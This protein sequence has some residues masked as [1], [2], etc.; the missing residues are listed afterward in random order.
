MC[1]HPFNCQA[2]VT[3]EPSAVYARPIHPGVEQCQLHPLVGLSFHF[4]INK[5]SGY[6][7]KNQNDW[8]K[9]QT[10]EKRND[11]P[12]CAIITLADC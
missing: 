2:I 9:C 8:N 3:G 1:C 4:S 12:P 7:R 5:F 10:V 6:G 11:W